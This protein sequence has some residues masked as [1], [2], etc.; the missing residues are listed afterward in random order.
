MSG[1]MTRLGIISASRDRE[2]GFRLGFLLFGRPVGA[3]ASL[4]ILE[5]T[6]ASWKRE[7]T[8]ETAGVCLLVD[9]VLAERHEPLVVE[10]MLAPAARDDDISLVEAQRH[11]AGHTLLRYRDEC[12]VRLAFG[13]APPLPAPDVGVAWS[14]QVFRPERSPREHH[15]IQCRMRGIHQAT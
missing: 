11:R 13:R 12:V 6:N 5:R 15:P 14:E 3:L 7:Q 10:R 2:R 4:S 1:S 8:D 9:V